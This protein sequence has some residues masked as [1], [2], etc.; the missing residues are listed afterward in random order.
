[1]KIAVM[2][3]EPNGKERD[4]KII[5]L[6]IQGKRLAGFKLINDHKCCDQA[7]HRQHCGVC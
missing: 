6:E 3:R 4:T 7:S 2:Y 5:S 1:V